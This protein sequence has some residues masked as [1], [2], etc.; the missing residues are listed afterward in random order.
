[1]DRKKTIIIPVL[2]WY[3][4]NKRNLPWRRT[5]SP[6]RILVSEVMLQQTQVD[7]VI[8]KYRNFLR[9]FPSIKKLATASAG[10]VIIA[11]QG[12]GYNRRALYLQKTATALR[13]EYGG[14]FP[15][16]MALLKQLPGVGDY[17]ARALLSFAFDKPVAMLDTNHRKFYSRLFHQDAIF[18]DRNLLEKTQELVEE[19]LVTPTLFC[20]GKSMMYHWNQALM[21]F[22]A[23]F[24][25]RGADFSNCPIRDF[26]EHFP[27]ILGEKKKKNTIPFRQTDRYYRGRIV[28]LLRKKKSMKTKDIAQICADIPKSRQQHIMQGLVRDGLI[29]KVGYSM[30]LP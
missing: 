15:Q 18:S 19:F 14:R 8:S 13:K 16:D 29:K 24:L 27:E 4:Q 25:V 10:D 12:L 23:H 1:M 30:L 26:N 20:D 7:R 11:W 22:G 21:D 17:T 5:V 2:Q 9:Q 28:E 6:Y 3:S